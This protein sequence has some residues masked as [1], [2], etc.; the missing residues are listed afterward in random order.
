M[1]GF[2]THERAAEG[3]AS[4][5]PD[6]R[7]RR[8]L[9]ALPLALLA[10]AVSDAHAKAELPDEDV[11]FVPATA[12]ELED[13]HRVD[14]EPGYTRRTGRRSWMPAWPATWA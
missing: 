12:R 8:L 4:T 3:E 7:R 14:R 5:A 10:A 6:R 1:N 2:V 11:L 13:G 9:A